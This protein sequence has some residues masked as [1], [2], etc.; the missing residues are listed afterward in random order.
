[1]G[2]ICFVLSELNADASA[3][4][5]AVRFP[6]SDLGLLVR[7]LI[8]LHDTKWLRGFSGVSF[9]LFCLRTMKHTSLPVACLF[10]WAAL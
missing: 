3:C 7:I 10:G 2:V 9:G 8:P 6:G 5:L 4:G 1:M